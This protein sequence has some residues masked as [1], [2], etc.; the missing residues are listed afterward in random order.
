MDAANQVL[1]ILVLTLGFAVTLIVTQFVRRRPDLFAF[2]R[3]AAYDALPG[4]AALSVESGQPMAVHLGNAGLG[5]SESLLALASAELAYQVAVRAAFGDRAPLL[6][7]SSPTGLPLIQDTERRVAR[8]VGRARV[9]TDARWY[10]VGARSLAYAAALTALQSNEDVSSSVLV[11]RFGIELALAAESAARRG[12]PVIAATDRLD[13]QAVAYA[14]STHPLI[15][16]EL[17]QSGAYLDGGATRKGETVALDLLR[18]V[19][20]GVI[21]LVAVQRFLN[22][23]GG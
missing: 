14:F 2:R 19:L 5:G 11:G 21:A 10:P 15:G 1:T 18:I 8:K 20:I 7:T 3:Q 23:G 6:T 22:G 13:G 4:Y 17:F 9:F 16:E 12:H